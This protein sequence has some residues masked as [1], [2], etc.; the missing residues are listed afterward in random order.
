MATLEILRLSE[1]N[2]SQV[3]TACLEKICLLEAVIVR[4]FDACISFQF[5]RKSHSTLHDTSGWIYNFYCLL[6]V[7][8]TR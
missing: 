5:L 3:A 6:T 4:N 1:A 7:S 2:S 8:T